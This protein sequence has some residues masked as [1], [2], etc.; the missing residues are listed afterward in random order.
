MV[1]EGKPAFIGVLRDITARE[2]AKAV[3]GESDRLHRDLLGALPDAMT[4][5]QDG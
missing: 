4:I 1:W 3:L 2:E 5:H